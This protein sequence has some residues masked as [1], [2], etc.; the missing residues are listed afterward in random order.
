MET[1][2]LEKSTKTIERCQAELLDL[3]NGQRNWEH[4]GDDNNVESDRL[5]TESGIHLIKAVGLINRTPQQIFDVIWD[6]QHKSEW[7]DMCLE[8]ILVQEFT[9]DFRVQYQRFWAPWPINQ[10][11][12]VF[13][14]KVIRTDGDILITGKSIETELAPE[15]SG[16]VR[17]SINTSGFYLQS[18]G[19]NLTR[20]TYLVCVDPK[21]SIPTWVVNQ[22][23][24]RQCQI[25][26]KLKMRL[27]DV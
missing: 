12:F 5:M 15:K 1:S 7:D 3:I 19:E 25:V 17:G 21:G 26:H 11:D 23:G 22:L 20:I 13:A 9:P 18:L 24:K 8:N 10:R 14:S 27:G 6:Y 2:L 16:I 4:L